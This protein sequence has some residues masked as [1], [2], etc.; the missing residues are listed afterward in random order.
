MVRGHFGGFQWRS[1]SAG[2]LVC[3]RPRLRLHLRHL[4]PAGQPHHR[5]PG[6]SRPYPLTCSI[7][8]PVVNHPYRCTCPD[9]ELLATDSTNIT[10]SGHV[11]LPLYLSNYNPGYPSIDWFSFTI[12][13]SDPTYQNQ[14][15]TFSIDNAR[16]SVVTPGNTIVLDTPALESLFNRVTPAQL[17]T[18]I[19]QIGGAGGGGP[20]PTPPFPPGWLRIPVLL[21]G[22][23]APGS[24]KPSPNWTC[25]T[26]PRCRSA[27]TETRS[28]RAGNQP[29]WRPAAE[30]V[31]SRPLPPAYWRTRTSLGLQRRRWR[32]LAIS[33]RWRR[34]RSFLPSRGRP[35]HDQP[36]RNGH[37]LADSW[38]RQWTGSQ[39]YPKR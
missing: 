33:P 35:F 1:H 2:A 31:P 17:E 30:I 13:H 16:L 24:T 19:A 27:P 26:L 21:M 20:N 3:Q 10:A 37:Q 7:S 8:P 15:A 25:A 28:F 23:T 32:L 4:I 11:S 36:H 9:P 29:A 38:W 14:P 18:R 39:L 34:C 12:G 6:W 5:S 22:S